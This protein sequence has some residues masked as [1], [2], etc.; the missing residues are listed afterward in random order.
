[1]SKPRHFGR[2]AGAVD[3]QD[4]AKSAR[5][6]I[7]TPVEV[8]S[9]R[10]WSSAVQGLID[11]CRVVARVAGLRLLSEPERCFISMKRNATLSGL[12]DNSVPVHAT[13]MSDIDTRNDCVRGEN[14]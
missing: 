3:Q 10:A 1:M 11:D 2:A 9:F 12:S 8:D 7:R 13:S 14:H 5:S 4:P 6:N